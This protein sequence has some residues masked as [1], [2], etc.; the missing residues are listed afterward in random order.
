M[1][2]SYTIEGVVKEEAEGEGG[3]TRPASATKPRRA[4]E[5]LGSRSA[6]VSSRSMSPNSENDSDDEK[7]VKKAIGELKADDKMWHYKGL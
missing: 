5:T 7:A 2:S 1:V 6:T 4:E 3:A